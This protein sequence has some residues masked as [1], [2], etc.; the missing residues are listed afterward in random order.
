MSW[1]ICSNDH[2]NIHLRKWAVTPRPKVAVCGLS[3]TL[4]KFEKPLSTPVVSTSA[5]H[6]TN[7]FLFSTHS[8][9]PFSAYKPIHKPIIPQT[10]LTKGLRSKNQLLNSSWWPMYVFNSVEFAKSPCNYDRV[11][12]CSAIPRN[13]LIQPWP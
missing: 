13:T 12:I 2:W 10:A 7:L 5:F 6:S 4:G 3:P 1:S 11:H 9:A 8:V